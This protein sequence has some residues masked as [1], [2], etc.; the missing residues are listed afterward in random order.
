M[1]KQGEETPPYHFT[2]RHTPPV[3]REKH[4]I[5]LLLSYDGQLLA[6]TQQL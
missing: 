2:A 1:R 3:G 6:M 5:D 4:K